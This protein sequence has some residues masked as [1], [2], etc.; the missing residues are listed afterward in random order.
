ML[1][2]IDANHFHVALESVVDP[3]FDGR[4]VGVVQRRR[5]RGGPLAGNSDARRGIVEDRASQARAVLQ[6]R[7]RTQAALR[8]RRG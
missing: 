2:L 6:P 4:L 3:R 7:M 5:L 1:A 8:S